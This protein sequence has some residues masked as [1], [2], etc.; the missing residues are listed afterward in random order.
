[1][2]Y[3]IVSLSGGSDHP[4]EEFSGKTPLE[5]AKLTNLHSLAKIGKV[6]TVKLSSNRVVPSTDVTLLNLLGYDGSKIYTGRGPFEA[7]N[8]ELKLEDNETAFCMNFISEA[9][10]I[11]ADST[12]GS[13]TNKEAKALINFLNK[14]VASDFVRFFSGSGC[15]NVAVIKDA[16]GFA[17]LSAK[18][19]SPD[20]GI[21]KKIESI[22]PK[23]PGEELLKKLMYDAKLLLQDHEINQVRV[24]LGENPANMVWLWGQGQKPV[25]KP[26]SEL[27]DMTGAI[28]A[29]REFAKGLGR[30]AGLTVM[31]VK[32]NSEDVSELYERI[33]KAA[34]DALSEKDLV[35]I[36]LNNIDEA[37]LRG[38]LR[39]KIAALERIDFFILSK[40]KKY[41]ASHKDTRILVTTAHAT[42][43]KMRQQVQ[44]SVPFVIAGKNI[45][46]DEIEKFSE[47]AAKASDL[48]IT[49][50][51]ELMPFFLKG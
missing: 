47:I 48:K 7:A 16:H 42:L 4:V 13:I 25:M 46:S 32:E 20:A 22:L 17:A 29:V 31:E 34:I 35:C 8:L 1:M 21:G 36:H 39:G 45:V 6:G 33:A 40:L 24:D 19:I 50:G 37:S 30:L 2:K 5:A 12:A 51:E 27:F 44:E 3:I 38:D 18:T 43:W 26:F 14:K 15:R 23:G 49:K 11:L 9:A 28:V 41:M 10:G